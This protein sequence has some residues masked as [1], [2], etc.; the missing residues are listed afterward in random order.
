[1]ATAPSTAPVVEKAQHEPHW[2]WSLMGVTAPLLR[3]S[4][5]SGAVNSGFTF[6]ALKRRKLRHCLYWKPPAS[7]AALNSSMVMSANWLSATVYV[8]PILVWRATKSVFCANT[9]RR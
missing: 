6:I 4:T 3:Q 5:E 1:M 2:P 9:R 8:L 7:L